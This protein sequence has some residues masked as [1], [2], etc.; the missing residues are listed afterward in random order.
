MRIRNPD[1][2][3]FGGSSFLP[4][5]EP[6]LDSNPDRIH[7][8]DPIRI[9]IRNTEL[10]AVFNQEVCFDIESAKG[11]HNDLPEHRNVKKLFL[12]YI[13]LGS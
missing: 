6:E 1:F 12:D 13:F 2:V 7:W 4:S 3:Y 9:R 10:Y 5:L 11:E 8:L